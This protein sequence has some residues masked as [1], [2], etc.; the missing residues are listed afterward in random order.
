LFPLCMD[1]RAVLCR[2]ATVLPVK[3]PMMACGRGQAMVA[4]KRVF[5][6]GVI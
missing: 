1:E 6:A 5:P 4:R 3:A 2:T